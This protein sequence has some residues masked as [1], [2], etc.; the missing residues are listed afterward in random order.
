MNNKFLLMPLIMLSLG[1]CK[2]NG[3]IKETVALS[4][5][6]VETF[7]AVNTTSSL[8][9]YAY[10]DVVF[11]SYFIGA[12]KCRFINCSVSYYYIY[13]ANKSEIFTVELTLSGCGQ[14]IP[15]VVRNLP[16]N[17]TY[18][19]KFSSANGTVEVGNL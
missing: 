11:Y 1:G 17:A 6:N 14:A 18:V 8:T 9:Q 7:V 10:D 13:G 4:A 15:Y 16:R 12:E 5:K 3:G 19:L 2:T